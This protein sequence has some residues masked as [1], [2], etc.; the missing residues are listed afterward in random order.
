MADID[1]SQN[2]SLGKDGARRKAEELVSSLGASYGIKGSWS[3]DVFNI[4]KPVE[5]KVTVGDTNVRVELS[6][7]F[8]M[9]MMKGKIEEE[10]R[11]QLTR[12]LT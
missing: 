9:R 11:K 12:A 6:L 7:G 8:A 2:H 5:G 10:V 1:L 4:T 3:G